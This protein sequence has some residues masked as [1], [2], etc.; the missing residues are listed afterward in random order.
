M[1]TF[2]G[3]INVV[4]VGGLVLITIAAIGGI[5]SQPWPWWQTLGGVACIFI[6]LGLLL[7]YAKIKIDE[8]LNK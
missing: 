8:Q 3:V 4:F 1:K 6:G 2:N 5:V 7:S